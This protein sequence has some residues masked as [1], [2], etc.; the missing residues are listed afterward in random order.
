MS[1]QNLTNVTSLVCCVYQTKRTTKRNEKRKPLKNKQSTMQHNKTNCNNKFVLQQR[2]HKRDG[3]SLIH[4]RTVKC[5]KLMADTS[6]RLTVT[7]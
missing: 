5:Y 1:D 2:R 3:I 6:V 4:H 7:L